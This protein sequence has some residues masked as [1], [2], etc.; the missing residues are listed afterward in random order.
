MSYGCRILRP[1]YGQLN[2]FE[3][4]L[5]AYS[6]ERGNPDLKPSYINNVSLSYAFGQ[7]LMVRLSF[8]NRR[9]VITQLS[10]KEEG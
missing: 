7:S 9:D 5:D 6:F 3:I 8:D 1:N 2:P 10:V 4:K